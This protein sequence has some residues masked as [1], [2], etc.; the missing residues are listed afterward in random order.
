[1]GDKSDKHG[2]RLDDELAKETQGLTRG[3]GPSHA[4]EWK[5]PEPVGTDTG[6]DPTAG[7]SAQEGTPQG[8][9]PRDVED[10]SAMARVLAGADYPADPGAL[11]R[12][13]AGQGAPD[14]A[15]AALENLPRRTYGDFAEV[16]DGLGIGHEEQRF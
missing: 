12:H 14:V 9:T 13:A 10:R 6:R 16:A 5:E 3:T 1:M 4:E 11:A 15:V 8:M 7:Y 2:S